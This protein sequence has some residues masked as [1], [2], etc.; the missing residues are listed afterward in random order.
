MNASFIAFPQ[1]DPVIFEIGSVGLRW[2]GLMY[3]IGFIFARWLAIQRAKKPY[4]GWTV[5]QIDSLLFNGFLGVFLG[6]RI[7]YVLFYQWDYF[8]QEP[9]YLFRVW[10]GGMSFHGGL[11]GVIISMLITVKLQKRYFWATADF[12]APLIPFGLG[13]G[14]IGNF[15]N[16]ELWGRVTD[17]SWAVLFPSGGYL[18]RH[19]SQLY[20]AFLEGFVL[21]I[22]LNYFI[23]K[24]RPTGSVAGLFL[25]GY[26][27]FRFLVEFFREPD[28]QLGLY[29]GQHISMGQIL[30]LPMIILG[31]LIMT[32]AYKSA[33]KK[34]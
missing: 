6:G 30:S 2:Y 19:P 7:G 13:M 24:P 15:I 10:E 29:F 8:L 18:P 14:R 1:F 23:G 26:G 17:V 34:G 28:P 27:S 16:D 22:I 20:E 25:I 9:A 21:F 33:V 12:V 4:S 5:E 31:V 11:I 3:L 32:I